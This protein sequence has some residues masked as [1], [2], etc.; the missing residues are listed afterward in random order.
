MGLYKY[1]LVTTQ[2]L[3]QKRK[4]LNRDQLGGGG[5]GGAVGFA[6][7]RIFVVVGK[8]YLWS[9]STLYLLAC[10][11]RVTVGDSGLCCVC[12]TFFER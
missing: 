4:R 5:G 9:V 8:M 1:L 2:T 11:V 3:Q 10:Q 12:A 7:I 6:E